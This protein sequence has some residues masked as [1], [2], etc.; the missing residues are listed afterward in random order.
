MGRMLPSSREVQRELGESTQKVENAYTLRSVSLLHV[1][2]RGADEAFIIYAHRWILGLLWYYLMSINC[3]RST[4]L[5]SKV[6]IY[7]YII[8]MY[9]T[10]VR[11]AFV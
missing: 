11:N 7:M 9:K 3:D 8:Q 4:A 6:W 5:L 10:Y 1:Y 2:M